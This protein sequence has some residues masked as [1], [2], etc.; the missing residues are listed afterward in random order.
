[1]LTKKPIKPCSGA[2]IRLA[3]GVPTM[4]VGAISNHGEINAILQQ[5]HLERPTPDES[6]ARLLDVAVRAGAELD[7]ST[8]RKA[9]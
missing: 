6:R 8:K 1:M 9:G 3:T 4:T 7:R 5:G 2:C